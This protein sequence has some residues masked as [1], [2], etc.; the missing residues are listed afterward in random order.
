MSVTIRRGENDIRPRY[1]VRPVTVDGETTNVPVDVSELTTC[2]VEL[3]QRGHTVATFNLDEGERPNLRAGSDG[4]SV[5]IEYTSALT[6]LLRAGP[7]TEHWTIAKANPDY[8][9]EP[10]KEIHVLTAEEVEIIP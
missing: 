1:L 9:A 5:N 6:M 8:V 10:G 7:V 2:R 4:Q 3:R